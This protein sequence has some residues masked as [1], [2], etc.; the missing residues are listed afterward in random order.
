MMKYMKEQQMPWVG[1]AYEGNVSEEF[2][3]SFKYVLNL[4][5]MMCFN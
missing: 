1:I 5:R 3:K 4:T 2:R